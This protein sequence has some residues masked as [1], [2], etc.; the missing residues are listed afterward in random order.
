MQLR[1]LQDWVMERYLKQ[2]P[3]VADVVSFGG[4]VKQYQV[5]VDPQR[6]QARGVSLQQV[7]A[8]LAR[9][10]ANAGGNYI[11]HGEE[12]YVVRGLG[13]L[14]KLDDIGQVVVAAR[15]GIPIRIRDIADVT[16]GPFPRRGVVTRDREP[17]AV[18]G[19]VLMR[20]GENPSTVL[21]ALHAKIEQLNHGILPPGVQIDTFYDRSRL[22]RRTLTTVTRNLVVGAILLVLVVGAFLMS[23]PAAVIVALV[24][25]VPLLRAFLYLQ[26]R[27]LSA[28]LLS[29]GAVDFGII[30]DGA[31]I[32]IEHVTR[33]L[34]G[35]REP[36][37]ARSAV[38][39]A[40]GEVARPTLFALCIIIVAYIPIFSL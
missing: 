24:S 26:V 30:V 40:A 16:I 20:R 7:F 29:L 11:E 10:N 8:A 3:G 19:I 12:Q 4:F 17:E 21:A 32:M 33:R 23:V 18:E 36:R 31:V 5:Q 34:S 35:I 38:L 14:A 6:L 37:E 39:E 22:V 27:G 13:T 9:S 28:S 25:P 15:G 1:E 2:V